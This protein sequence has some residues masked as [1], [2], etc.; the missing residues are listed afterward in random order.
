MPRPQRTPSE[1]TPTNQ[2]PSG[3]WPELDPDVSAAE[4]DPDVRSEVAALSGPVADRV[5]RHLVMAGRLL[6]D[7]PAGAYQHAR[8]ARQ[9]APRVAAVREALGTTAYATGAYAEALAELRTARRI[10]GSPDFLA[11][12]ADCERGLGR[13]QRAIDMAGHPDAGRLDLPT[14][15][16]LLI[17]VSGAR[18]DLGLGEAAVV[19]LQGPELRSADR[20][21]WG[22][23]LQ[24]AYAEAL[25]AAG[26]RRDAARWFARAAAADPAGET[27][28]DERQLRLAAQ[29]D[30]PPPG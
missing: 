22:M 17:V 29:G 25:L 23:R 24:Y 19:G 7:E 6:D 2:P 11:V 28:A 5:A 10:N 18:R 30:R 26:R 16:E 27:D 20:E 15:V 4:L 3:T 13:P 9:L 8:A 1:R 14:R 21:P 12:M